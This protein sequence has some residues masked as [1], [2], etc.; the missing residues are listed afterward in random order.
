VGGVFGTE[1]PFRVGLAVRIESEVRLRPDA[2]TGA[3]REVWVRSLSINDRPLLPALLSRWVRQG[4]EGGVAVAPDVAR[5]AQ[6]I[7]EALLPWLKPR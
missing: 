2:Q 3:V 6:T 5:D 4:A 1:S 7:V